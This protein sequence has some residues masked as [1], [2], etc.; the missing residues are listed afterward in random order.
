LAPAATVLPV[1]V[2]RTNPA[3]VWFMFGTCAVVYLSYIVFSMC[4]PDVPDQVA[5]RLERQEELEKYLVMKAVK[6]IP[7][8]NHGLERG[9]PQTYWRRTCGLSR[10]VFQ[11]YTSDVLFRDGKRMA[12]YTPATAKTPGDT[13][14]NDPEVLELL[15][16]RSHALQIQVD[17]EDLEEDNLYT[18]QI[19]H[20]NPQFFE[21]ITPEFDP[22]SLMWKSLADENL[23]LLGTYQYST[24]P[25][26]QDKPE[27]DCQLTL[28]EGHQATH[29]NLGNAYW[30]VVIT[31]DQE[32][33]DE[34]AS[35]E[36]LVEG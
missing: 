7:F 1:W 35:D 25:L 21:L 26:N 34:H 6:P 2:E 22:P 33:D 15:A 12:G 13:N 5:E 10:Y 4:I 9:I 3:L 23:T 36:K 14:P 8:G 31:S 18:F 32:D 24:S 16:E 17:F 28:K 11:T 27:A 20:D 30:S 19:N 29:T